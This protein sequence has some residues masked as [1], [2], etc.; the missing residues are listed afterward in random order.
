MVD[1]LEPRL[2]L[3]G[4]ADVIPIEDLPLG[5]GV[6]KLTEYVPVEVVEAGPLDDR[7]WDDDL[8]PWSYP[9]DVLA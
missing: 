5:P 6:P 4:D 8:V 1:S 7:H 3:D 9:A 2:P